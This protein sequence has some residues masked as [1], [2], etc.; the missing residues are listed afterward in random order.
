MLRLSF[1]L[2]DEALAIEKAVEG[3]LED[4]YRTADISKGSQANA[5]TSKIGDLISGAI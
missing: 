1:N 4:G 2:N 5:D 3:I